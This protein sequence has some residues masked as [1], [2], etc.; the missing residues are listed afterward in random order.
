MTVRPTRKSGASVLF[1]LIALL[2]ALP[3]AAQVQT[4]S[5]SVVGRVTSGSEAL[6]GVT[7][8][9][10]GIGAPQTFVTTNAGDFRFL[11]LYPGKYVVTTEMSGFAPTKRAVEVQIGH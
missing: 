1:V 8:T 3:L 9:I 11:N 5:G 7:V 6:P 10:S 2:V 4:Q